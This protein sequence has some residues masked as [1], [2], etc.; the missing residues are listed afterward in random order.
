MVD[1]RFDLLIFYCFASK[2]SAV[3]YS[4]SSWFYLFM[5][6][7]MPTTSGQRR[8][9]SWGSR[10]ARHRD[11]F[12]LDCGSRRLSCAWD[13]RVSALGFS[14]ELRTAKCSWEWPPE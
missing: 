10:R 1:L 3:F 12:T 14:S 11:G 6:D 7:H 9:E 5:H 13:S 8:L 2:V 4:V